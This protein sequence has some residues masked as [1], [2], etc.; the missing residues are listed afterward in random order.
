MN[1]VILDKLVW[2]NWKR[3]INIHKRHNMSIN[4]SAQNFE[5]HGRTDTSRNSF[6]DES[7][8]I[9]RVDTTKQRDLFR[10]DMIELFLLL[11]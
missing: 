6:I 7:D 10:K 5:I 2:Y 9:D 8:R 4:L 11:V 1:V 3:M